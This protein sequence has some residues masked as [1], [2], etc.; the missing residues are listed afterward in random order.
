MSHP[1]HEAV[2]A[3]FSTLMSIEPTEDVLVADLPHVFVRDV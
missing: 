3:L 2:H 1:Q